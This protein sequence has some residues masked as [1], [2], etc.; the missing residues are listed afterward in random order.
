MLFRSD[1][2]ANDDALQV[3]LYHEGKLL[4]LAAGE[5]SDHLPLL[6]LTAHEEKTEQPPNNNIKKNMEK[7]L[8]KLGLAQTATEDDAVAEI[9]KLQ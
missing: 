9:K 4:T 5:E 3:G 6:N 2:G 8:T 7:I 1:I